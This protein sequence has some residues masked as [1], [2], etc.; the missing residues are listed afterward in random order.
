VQHANRRV[1]TVVR[2]YSGCLGQLRDRTQ[3]V[4]SMRAGL[5][6]GSALSRRQV[7]ARV[8]L[9]VRRV[10]R[11]ERRGVR[12]LQALGSAGGCG[13][14]D[15]RGGAAAGSASSAAPPPPA[16]DEA[17]VDAATTAARSGEVQ[18]QDRS[19]VKGVAA[20]SVPDS[21]ATIFPGGPAASFINVA[22][23]LALVGIALFA[24]AVRRERRQ[25]RLE[26]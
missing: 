9:G 6:P 7:A 23:V 25:R 1:R 21:P 10:T 15:A 3:T 12:R 17:S 22:P 5:G 20:R 16:G 13:A 4:L 18:G 14:A 2:R 19:G 26:T 8:D 11:L 24:L